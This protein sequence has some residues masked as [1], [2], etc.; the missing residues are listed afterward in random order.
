MN[1]IVIRIFFFRF[2][3]VFPP[4]LH[5]FTRAA[6][7]MILQLIVIILQQHHLRI[8]IPKLWK[9]FLI[10]IPSC[11]EFLMRLPVKNIHPLLPF[12]MHL[13]D[14]FP[15]L[16]VQP[17]DA[18]FCDFGTKTM[19]FDAIL[20]FS[21]RFSLWFFSPT[22][23]AS[24]TLYCHIPPRLFRDPRTIYT[25]LLKRRL[26]VAWIRWS[27]RQ[28]FVITYLLLVTSFLSIIE[29]LTKNLKYLNRNVFIEKHETETSL[30]FSF[31]IWI[32]HKFCLHQHRW[33]KTTHV[34]VPTTRCKM[35]ASLAM[36]W[37][38]KENA[39][40]QGTVECFKFVM[41]PGLIFCN[42]ILS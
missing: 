33:F 28:L 36:T 38:W 20:T 37:S 5:P 6:P 41:L 29:G 10:N 42:M 30:L 16:F 13:S 4:L 7:K 22:A 12:S 18:K 8:N 35:G 3:F 11:S 15:P 24:N 32:G 17:Y 1:L 19:N 31:I 23:R 39:N 27:F 26:A 25:I 2:P 21:T 9:C 34:P 14:F 40:F